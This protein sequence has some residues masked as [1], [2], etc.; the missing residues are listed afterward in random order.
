MCSSDLK[1]HQAGLKEEKVIKFAQT[2]MNY[3][4][5][6][7]DFVLGIGRREIVHQADPVMSWQVNNLRWIK[8]HTGLYMPDKLKS[9]EKIDGPVAAIMAYGRATH[10]DNAKLLKAKPKVS[11]L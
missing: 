6:C 11:T 7:N 1:M 10:P 8:N 5:P 3:A 2:M 4:S 9:V